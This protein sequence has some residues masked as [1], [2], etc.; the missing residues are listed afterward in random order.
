MGIVVFRNEILSEF[1]IRF[2]QNFVEVTSY[3]E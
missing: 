3:L 1:K 2:H